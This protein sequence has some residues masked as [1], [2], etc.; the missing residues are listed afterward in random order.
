MLFASTC[1]R[2]LQPRL[3]RR[4]TTASRWTVKTARRPNLARPSRRGRTFTSQPVAGTQGEATRK[5]LVGGALFG[6]SLIAA[7]VL[8]NRETREDGG[9]PP[10]ERSY[11][12]QTFLHT[13]LGVGIIG[14]TARAM[15]RSGFV[16]R[17]MA[18]NPWVVMVGG[19]ALSFGTMMGTR[20]TDP[21][22]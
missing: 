3:V 9:M 11:L 22:R 18:T 15:H 21:S 17:I 7:N 1:V 12:N 16:Y 8:L 20:A 6:G 13:G 14:A 5:L 10:Y 2:P 19:L 4:L